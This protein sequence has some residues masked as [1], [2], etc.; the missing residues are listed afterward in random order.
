MKFYCELKQ[1]FS[2]QTSQMFSR[3]EKLLFFV[4]NEKLLPL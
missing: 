4:L 1:K 3:F 2:W